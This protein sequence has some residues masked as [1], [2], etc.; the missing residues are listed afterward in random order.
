MKKSA[1]ATTAG[2]PDTREFTTR[3]AD[4]VEASVGQRPTGFIL[5]VDD[6][7][8]DPFFYV[9]Y[10]E[11]IDDRLIHDAVEAAD[12]CRADEAPGSAYDR[13]DRT[14]PK[15]PQWLHAPGSSSV[16]KSWGHA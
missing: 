13:W 14:T 16:L 4:A 10:V 12:E 7:H 11:G 9:E 8:P 5:A 2:P 1:L 6:E 3:W 15:T